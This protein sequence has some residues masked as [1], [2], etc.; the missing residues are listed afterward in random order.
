MAF[1]QQNSL[2]KYLVS[3]HSRISQGSPLRACIVHNKYS[4]PSFHC[5]S[6]PFLPPLPQGAF[7]GTRFPP[8]NVRPFVGWSFLPQAV[9]IRTHLKLRNIIAIQPRTADNGTSGSGLP[10]DKS[11]P[12]GVTGR[13]S[14]VF[15]GPG[16]KIREERTDKLTD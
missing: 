2:K 7:L 8:H 4:Y 11:R 14:F 12:R 10:I 13:Y 9:V 3:G 1:P 16:T 5:P 6:V 15:P